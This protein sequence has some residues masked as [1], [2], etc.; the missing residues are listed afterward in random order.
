MAEKCCTITYHAL[1]TPEGAIRPGGEPTCFGKW[2][3]HRNKYKFLRIKKNTQ[4]ET[5]GKH[6]N[7]K[8]SNTLF[9]FWKKKKIIQQTHENPGLTFRSGVVVNFFIC[10]EIFYETILIMKT[11]LVGFSFCMIW[12]IIWLQIVEAVIHIDLK[13][14]INM[15]LLGHTNF[16]ALHF[17]LPH[18][19]QFHKWLLDLQ[20]AKQK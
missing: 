15:L 1:R 7:I 5:K 2:Q 6:F 16:F 14:I 12:G 11:L 17:M 19:S 18:I 20:L 13:W 8:D 4:R 10:L 9:L 3:W